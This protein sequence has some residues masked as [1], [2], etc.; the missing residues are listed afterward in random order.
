MPYIT[1]S[2]CPLSPMHYFSMSRSFL[3]VV[4]GSAK[5]AHPVNWAGYMLVG[6]DIV[7][8]DRADLLARG[9]RS[10]LQAT[11]DTLVPALRT[12]QAM[13]SPTPPTFNAQVHTVHVYNIMLEVI[14]EYAGVDLHF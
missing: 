2:M 5:Y 13:V 7:L 10:M 8:R 9:F 1:I 12:M 4:H 3:Q 6:K 11:E 14:T